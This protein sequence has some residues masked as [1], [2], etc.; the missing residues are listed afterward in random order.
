MVGAAAALLAIAMIAHTPL[1]PAVTRNK[2]NFFNHEALGI[3]YRVQISRMAASALQQPHN[4]H[5]HVPL[6][7][8]PGNKRN[9][10]LEVL[11]SFDFVPQLL[12][13]ALHAS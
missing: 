2:D 12:V 6:T 7:R 13:R 4:V 5:T 9:I 3:D 11:G 10:R 1:K 8:L